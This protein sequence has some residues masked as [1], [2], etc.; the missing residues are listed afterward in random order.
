M[1]REGQ[2]ALIG[3]SRV[4]RNLRWSNLCIRPGRRP[5][6]PAMTFRAARHWA[7]LA[8][9]LA[10]LVAGAATAFGFE[11]A[12]ES[13]GHGEA[14]EAERAEDE[15]ARPEGEEGAHEGEEQ[16]QG[17]EGAHEADEDKDG[18]GMVASAILIGLAGGAVA[19]LAGLVARRREGEAAADAAAGVISALPLQLAMLSTGAAVVHFAVI[20]QH[21]DEW[22]LTGVFFIVVALFQLVWALLVVL[23]P[24]V[25]V[26]ASG[27]VVNAL[28]VAT[29]IGSR[30]TGVPVGPEAGE[31][32]PV[33]FP[34]MLATAFEVLVALAVARVYRPRD[35]LP[36]LRSGFGWSLGVTV[37]ALTALALAILA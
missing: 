26:Y 18:P 12:P 19:P 21:L 28:V 23:R 5:F 4:S 17:A 33:G 22:W 2:E 31:A 14:A 9:V 6:E 1:R 32:E 11:F 24:S 3:R 15:E 10:A 35:R 25:L 34:D 37:A 16:A 20:A 29:W 8:F 7:A 13:H 27:A 36:A 30:T